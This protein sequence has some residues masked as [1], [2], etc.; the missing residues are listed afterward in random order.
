MTNGPTGLADN[1]E[2]VRLGNQTQQEILL[3]ISQ[4]SEATSARKGKLGNG[5]KHALCIQ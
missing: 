3:D 1:E 4:Q 5:S 2:Y